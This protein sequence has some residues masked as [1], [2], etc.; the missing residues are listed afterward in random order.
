MCHAC[1]GCNHA[2]PTNSKSAELIYHFPIEAPMMVLHIDGYSAGKQV[3][4]K[5]SETY[6]IACCGMCTFAAMEPVTNPSA[7]TFAS[8]IM[9]II[10]RYGFCHTVVLDKDSKFFGVC[11]ESLDLLKINCHILSGG[12]HNPMLVKRLNRYLNKRLKIMVNE[13]DS[14]RITLEALLLLIYAW[15][16]CPVPGT[17]I[18]RSLVAV[19]REFQFPINFSS[20]K[21]IKLMSAPGTV[22]S[23]SQEL[24]SRL[25]ACCQIATIFVEED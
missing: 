9:K 7:T 2:N 19:G 16:S 1:P 4:F 13:R 23:Y 5:G 22:I 8:A 18:S 3:G 17:N 10:L 6:I 15:N 24:P 14:P 11:G 21:H 25:S 12:N 20:G